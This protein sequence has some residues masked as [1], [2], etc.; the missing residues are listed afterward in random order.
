MQWVQCDKCQCWQH[1]T[2]GL[3]ND[4]KDVEGKAEYICPKCYLEEIESGTRVP[5]P[6]AT[7]SEAKDLP[8][9]NLSDHIEERLSKRLN[10]EREE[11]SKISG[12]EPS[13]VRSRTNFVYNLLYN[14][15]CNY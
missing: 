5:L 11:M 13:E 7:A 15:G 12:M 3:Y 6:Q 2:C 14:F 4:E 9:T 1:R 10:Q 8:R